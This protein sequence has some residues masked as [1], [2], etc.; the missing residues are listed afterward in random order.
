MATVA[1]EAIT[2]VAG[3]G[4]TIAVDVSTSKEIVSLRFPVKPPIA[5]ST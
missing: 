4:S 1:T 3:K 5:V 2:K